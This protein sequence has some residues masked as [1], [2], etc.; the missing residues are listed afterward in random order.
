MDSSCIYGTAAFDSAPTIAYDAWSAP[1]NLITPQE[2]ITILGL[3]PD[4]AVLGQHYYVPNP[5]GHGL[6]PKWDFTSSGATAG[7][8]NAYVIG[9]K[10]GD[11]PSTHSSNIDNLMIKAVEG[12]LASEIFRVETNG[13]QPP[14]QCSAGDP[15]ITVKYTAQYCEWWPRNLWNQRGLTNFQGS[16]TA[17]FPI[18]FDV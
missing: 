17:L 6:S 2:L 10:V 4:P 13:G 12:E 1:G 5:V 15:N 11:L 3:V 9:V 8:P 14:S 18:R 16:L 7:N